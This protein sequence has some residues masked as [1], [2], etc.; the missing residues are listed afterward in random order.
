MSDPAPAADFLETYEAEPAR[1]PPQANDH[2]PH[3][4]EGWIYCPACDGADQ[5]T[6]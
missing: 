5:F 6:T 3:G 1:E 2:C 4:C